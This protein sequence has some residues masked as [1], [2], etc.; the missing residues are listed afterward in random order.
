MSS[1][2]QPL[3]GVRELSK[4]YKGGTLAN[5]R[6][7]FEI[8]SG[9][10]FGLLGPNGAG[11]TTLVKQIIGLLRPTSGAIV[12]DGYDLVAQPAAARQL[13]SFLPQGSLPID[14]F[15]LGEVVDL[16]GRIRGGDRATV[17]ERGRRLIDALE[18][19][20]WERSPGHKLSGGVRRLA[21][22]VMATVWPGRLVILDEPTND[23]DPLRR[24]LLWKEVRRLGREGIAVLLVTHNVLEAEQSVDRLAVIDQ[25]RI[26]AQGTASA[27]KAQER[28][29]L[30]LQVSLVPGSDSPETPAFAQQRLRLGRRLLLQIDEADAGEAIHWARAL[31]ERSE[32]EE[33]ALAASTLED[34]YIRLIG[35]EDALDGDEA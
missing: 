18:L 3:L 2:S 5:D 12:L 17:R 26:L 1:P 20:E 22:F 33:Y 30:R 28:G 25:G 8:E 19:Q 23:I 21:G 9:E 7:D 15:K 24:R 31:V 16:I 32:A 4:S 10:V 29:R 27:L 35:R 34:V 11:K 13:C 6:L 14:S